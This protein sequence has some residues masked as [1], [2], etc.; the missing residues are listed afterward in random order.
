MS[1]ALKNCRHVPGWVKPFLGA[2]KDGYNEQNAANM[3][4]IGTALV[5]KHMGRDPEFKKSYEDTF[6][7]RR[8]RPGHGAW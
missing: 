2:I 4:G 7:T 6:A 3:A 8:S 5:R 1:Q